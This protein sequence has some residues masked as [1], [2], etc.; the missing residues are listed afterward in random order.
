MEESGSH[1]VVVN[2]PKNGRKNVYF[3]FDAASAFDRR[4]DG[5]KLTLLLK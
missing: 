5:R 2:Y 4:Q 3:G 1:A